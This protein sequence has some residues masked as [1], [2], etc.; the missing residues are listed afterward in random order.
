M[1]FGNKSTLVGRLL[2][3]PPLRWIG[4]VSY[5][6]YLWHQPLL[7]FVRLRYNETPQPPT[8]LIV[9][10]LILPLSALSYICVEQPFRNKERIS[11]KYLF[12]GVVATT[13]LTLAMAF[14]LIR[15]AH[16]RALTIGKG[17]DTYLAE[18]QKY[19]NWQ[20]VVR[21]FDNVVANKKTFS[22]KS[23]TLNTSVALIGDSFAQ[24][25]Y[26][27]ILE[28]KHL[29]KYEIR[30]YYV[31]AR[32]QIYMGPEDRL[33]LIEAQ[34]RKIC[35]DAYDIKYAASL[36]RQANVIILAGYWQM[37]SSLRLPTTLQLLNFTKQ[38]QVFVI[39]PKHFGNVNPM[40]YVNKTLAYLLKQYQNP[41]REVVEVNRALEQKIDSSLFVNV[42]KM[43]C[44]GANQT[45]PL[46]TRNG[47]LISH[48]GIHLTKYGAL[49][50]GN[51]IF[52][53]KPLNVL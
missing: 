47:K 32:C 29:E 27:M 11:R 53:N 44:T 31:S 24:D 34:Y 36:I 8:V 19:G 16:D 20:Y 46:F 10:S 2:S 26:N 13:V 21:A 4:L 25:F 49:H 18:L 43:V 40:Q 39:G 3:T 17:G 15:T 5:S 42:Q 48:D 6:A 52:R 9:V 1:L 22:N 14:F 35:T 50:V 37:W 41:N 7:A 33:K 45:C 23:F 30:V 38:Q 28:G 12:F 51:V